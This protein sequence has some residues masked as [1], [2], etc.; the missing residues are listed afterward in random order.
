MISTTNFSENKLNVALVGAGIKGH[1]GVIL[2]TLSY[3]NNINVVAF[4]DNTPNKI[5]KK[6]YGIP[7]IG[8]IGKISEFEDEKIDAFHVTIGDNKARFDISNK[9]EAMGIQLFSIIIW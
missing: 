8:G 4:F 9:L 2:D 5:N 7:V 1:A 3:F 6:I